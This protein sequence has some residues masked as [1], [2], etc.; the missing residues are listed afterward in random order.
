[1]SKLQLLLLLFLSATATT[2]TADVVVSSPIKL[3]G[4]FFGGGLVQYYHEDN[5]SDSSGSSID[6]DADADA[7]T[8]GSSNNS[9]CDTVVILIVGTGMSVGDYDDLATAIAADTH[10]VVAIMDDNTHLIPKMSGKKAAKYANAVVEG[11]SQHVPVCKPGV[12]PANGYFFGGHSAG[13]GGAINAIA[14]TEA[15]N[16]NGLGLNFDVAGFIGMS[17]YSFKGTLVVPT[18]VWDFS[19]MSCLVCPKKAGQLAYDSVLNTDTRVFYQV[20]TNNTVDIVLGGDHCSYADSGCFAMCKGSKAARN[21]MHTE[22]AA[23]IH[24]FVGATVSGNFEKSE[25]QIDGPQDVEVVLYTGS[26]EVVNPPKKREFLL[27]RPLVP[28]ACLFT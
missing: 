13:G 27:V 23:S 3:G 28:I 18:L 4:G 5:P 7:V 24:T 21:F 22:L 12:Q 25:F 19:L 17:P 1:M 14:L 6:I 8:F 2:V 15:N 16:N 10:T 11:L 9:P 26:E 20:Q